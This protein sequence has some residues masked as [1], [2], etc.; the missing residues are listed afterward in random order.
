MADD[1]MKY[2][3]LEQGRQPQPSGANAQ[4]LRRCWPCT[5]DEKMD[6]GNDDRANKQGTNLVRQRFI[7]QRPQQEFAQGSAG[8][9]GQHEQ[10][11]G[12]GGGIDQQLHRIGLWTDCASYDAGKPSRKSAKEFR[13][14][15]LVGNTL[16]R[17]CH[18][19]ST[20]DCAIS[21]RSADY[22]VV[23]MNAE[24]QPVHTTGFPFPQVC[25]KPIIQPLLKP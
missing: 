15:C 9:G 6:D 10:Q 12:A 21:R 4:R 5:A 13:N 17:C 2:G 11:P 8:N 1:K 22:S 19:N 7:Q 23:L 24:I 3:E 20:S 14:G 18:S 16:H 25:P